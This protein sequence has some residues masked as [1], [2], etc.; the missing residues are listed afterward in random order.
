[1]KHEYK[2]WSKK[3]WAIRLASLFKSK[4]ICVDVLPYTHYHD[5]LRRIRR[6][7]QW[8]SRFSFS[9]FYPPLNRS[10]IFSEHFI[11]FF[12]LNDIATAA[13]FVLVTYI[14]IFAISMYI[15]WALFVKNQNFI[16]VFEIIFCGYH[17]YEH[18]HIRTQPTKSERKIQTQ[19]MVGSFAW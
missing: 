14:Q 12:I 2:R 19:I 9:Y 4:F 15:P 16:V 5:Y 17:I 8:F 10:I 7:R 3:I 1:M 13:C 18:N 11:F 6:R